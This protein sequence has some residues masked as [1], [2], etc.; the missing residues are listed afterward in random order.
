[1]KILSVSAQKPHSTGSGTYMT[2]LVNA[3]A[4]DG[5][6]QSVVFGITPEDTFTLPEGVASYPVFYRGTNAEDPRINIPYPV[7]GMSDHMPYESTLYRDLTPEMIDQFEQ[8]FVHALEQAIDAL[9]PDLIICHH[10]FLLNAII[11]KHFPDRKIYGVCHGTD[12]RQMN[13]CPALADMIRPHVSGIDLFLAL[14]DEQKDRIMSIYGVGDDKVKVIGSG[15]NAALFNAEG[16]VSRESKSPVRIC[17]AG[18]LSRPKGVPEFLRTLI[19][20]DKTNEM[21]VTLAGGCQDDFVM[22]LV[23]S[24]PENIT[25]LGQI[26][27][28]Q[29]ADMF[30]ASD[31]FV[32][33]SYFEGLPL[34]LIEAM[35]CGAMP[36]CTDLPGVKPWLDKNVS[37]HNVIFVP[38]PEMATI[39]TPTNAGRLQFT[40]D[41]ADAMQTAID[42]VVAAG[43]TRIPDTKGITWDG[44]AARLLAF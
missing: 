17:Y 28:T 27:Q 8:A 10:L 38:M 43:R 24:L 29:L 1:M 35:A 37:D 26:P 5:H 4:R 32:L 20:L 3:F 33:P 40:C 16:R 2:E 12:L 30:R 19:M 13:N 21:K 6:Q 9:D 41:L 44:V 36:V 18:K 11:K 22:S 15:Y 39:D 42:K 34:V 23:N 7:V 25:W 31:I 14:H